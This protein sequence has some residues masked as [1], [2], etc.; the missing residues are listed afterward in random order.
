MATATSPV[1]RAG[2][3]V[4]EGI[5]GTWFYHLSEPKR[6]SRGLCMANTM[7]TAVPISAWGHR[8]HLN[9]RYCKR[10]EGLAVEPVK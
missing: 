8:S 7:R 5:A 1:I 10:C 2:L 6:F 4:T 3:I 9:E